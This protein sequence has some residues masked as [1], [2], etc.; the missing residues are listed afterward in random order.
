LTE[1]YDEIENEFIIIEDEDKYD[2]V[3]G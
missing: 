2:I 3:C 1:N